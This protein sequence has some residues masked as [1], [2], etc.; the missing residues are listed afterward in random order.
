MNNHIIEE[1]IKDLKKLFLNTPQEKEI[2][3]QIR[4]GL[5]DFSINE[6]LTREMIENKFGT[7]QEIFDSYLNELDEKFI[8]H[9][10][11]RH[12]FTKK[13]F[14]LIS[15]VI[16]CVGI[17]FLYR[18]NQLYQDTKNSSVK[19]IETIIIEE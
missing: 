8:S 14:I 9:A 16:L 13:L 10:V 7:P 1:Y 2:I 3:T 11:N 12:Y 6:E 4:K 17:F 19:E 5:Y 18:L 15:I